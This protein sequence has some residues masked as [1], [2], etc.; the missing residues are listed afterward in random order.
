M[1]PN[2]YLAHEFKLP[3]ITLE[4]TKKYIMETNAKARKNV[5]D[6][7]KHYMRNWQFTPLFHMPSFTI[8]HLSRAA[9]V[10]TAPKSHTAFSKVPQPTPPASERARRFAASSVSSSRSSKPLPLSLHGKHPSPDLE[11]PPAKRLKTVMGSRLVTAPGYIPGFT[12]QVR[13]Q[14]STPRSRPQESD[15]SQTSPSNHHDSVLSPTTRPVHPGSGSQLQEVESPTPTGKLVQVEAQETNQANKRKETAMSSKTATSSNQTM[16]GK[17]T[18]TGKVITATA[19]DK[20]ITSGNAI[21]TTAGKATPTPKA[22]TS[23]QATTGSKASPSGKTT[24][25]GNKKTVQRSKTNDPPGAEWKSA[26]KSLL[27]RI[28]LDSLQVL[29]FNHG[30]GKMGG[31]IEGWTKEQCVQALLNLQES[32]TKVQIRMVKDGRRLVP[33][34]RWKW[35]DPQLAWGERDE[36]EKEVEDGELESGGEDDYEPPSEEE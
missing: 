35:L 31:E 19:T 24:A 20:I 32:G 11:T 6:G 16:T 25:P 36:Y 4:S 34:L 3:R 27:R 8:E 23:G 15:R 18:A 10:P 17:A 26:T 9:G 14:T 12:E 30:L 33:D 29:C 5:E 28:R 1:V 13:P 2:D 21:T 22:T 7:P